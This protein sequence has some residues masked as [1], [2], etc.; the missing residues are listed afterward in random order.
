MPFVSLSS[1]CLSHNNKFD[2]EHGGRATEINCKKMQAH[3]AVG[4][5]RFL[6]SLFMKEDRV[7]LFEY[8]CRIHDKIDLGVLLGEKS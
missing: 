3:V 7:L 8:Y 4:G 1:N 2:F 6:S 5:M